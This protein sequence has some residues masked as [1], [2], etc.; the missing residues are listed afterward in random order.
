MMVSDPPFS[1]LRA[2]PKKRLGRW[3]ALASTPP[4]RI[5]PEAGETRDGV[6]HYHHVVATLHEALGLF[7][8]KSG[9]L[10]VA[11]GGLVERGCDYFGVDASGHVGN[12]LGTFVDEEHDDVCVGMVFG[13]GV[14]DVFEQDGL[15]GLRGSHD[16]RAL[17]LADGG[18]HIDH[19]G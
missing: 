7:E 6:E 17:T 19:A 16:K 4:E 18:E 13:N 11:L 14:G 15:T 3:R 10:H 9:D 1:M 12:L 2:A 5:L 8:H